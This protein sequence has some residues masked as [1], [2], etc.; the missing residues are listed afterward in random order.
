MNQCRK[1]KL[2][3][4]GGVCLGIVL[5]AAGFYSGQFQDIYQKAVIVCLECIGIG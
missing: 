1:N 2:F 3:W 5:M 4:L